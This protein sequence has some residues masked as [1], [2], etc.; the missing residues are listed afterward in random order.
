MCDQKSIVTVPCRN[1]RLFRR[2]SRLKCHIAE[3]LLRAGAHTLHRHKNIWCSH[4]AGMSPTLNRSSAIQCFKHGDAFKIHDGNLR[5][6]HGTYYS[7]AYFDYIAM[8]EALYCWNSVK[9]GLIPVSLIS[10]ACTKC[11]D[12]RDIVLRMRWCAQNTQW[13][14][15]HSRKLH[16][17][18]CLAT[19]WI[20][21]ITTLHWLSVT[22][23]LVMMP[24]I[25]GTCKVASNPGFPFEIFLQ[26]CETKSGTES[27]GSRLHVW[28]NCHNRLD[29]FLTTQH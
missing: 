4:E 2:T 1:Q 25:V 5:F 20:H 3:L 10:D 16:M 15:T 24:G 29:Y 22:S 8:F 23:C 13:N 12:R 9:G 6:L 21:R 14:N 27:L 26:S 17:Y 7:V 18:K 11:S 19:M 28:Y